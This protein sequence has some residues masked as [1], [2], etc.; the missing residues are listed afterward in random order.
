MLVPPRWWSLVWFRGGILGWVCVLGGLVGVVSLRRALR[1]LGGVQ[2][3]GWLVGLG[4]GW[5]F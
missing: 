1:V 5:P 2:F 4:V 3:C